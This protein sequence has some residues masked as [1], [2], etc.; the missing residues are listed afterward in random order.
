[1]STQSF[2]EVSENFNFKIFE[3]A[4][5][6]KDEAL[7]KVSLVTSSADIPSYTTK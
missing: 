6:K 7:R 4:A 2:W 1:M 5:Q 3:T